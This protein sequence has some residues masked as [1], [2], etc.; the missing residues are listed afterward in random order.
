[1]ANNCRVDNFH[2]R[3]TLSNVLSNPDYADRKC[4]IYLLHGYLKDQEMAALYQ[5]SK[6]KALVSLTHGEG[7]GLPVFEAAGYGL[8]VITTEWSGPCDFLF[9]PVGKKNGKKKKKAM[10]AKV[11]YDIKP[12]QDHAVWDGVLHRESMWAYPQEGSAKMKFRDMHRNYD[13]YKKNAEVLSEHVKENWTNETQ[14][15]KFLSHIDPYAN[16]IDAEDTEAF[17]IENWLKNLQVEVHE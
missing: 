17:E 1:M 6:V 8:P 13:A 3:A 12:I 4:K 2:T 14:Y 5:H 15:E 16:I 11:N 9:A 10:F 7:F